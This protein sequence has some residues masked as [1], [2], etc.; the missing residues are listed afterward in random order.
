LISEKTLTPEGEKVHGKCLCG[1]VRFE[2]S[3]EIP[4]LYQCHCSLCRKVT[5]SSANAAFKV[6]RAQFT[7]RAG[8]PLVHEYESESGFKSHF[9]SSC[10]SPLP[11]LTANDTAWWVPVGLLEGGREI[12]VVAHVFVGSRAPWDVIAESGQQ[13]EEMPDAETMSHLLKRS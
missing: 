11:N 8:E 7:W 12:Q 13:F 10:G 4:N 1:E 9:C 2:L 3:G 5:G 6:D